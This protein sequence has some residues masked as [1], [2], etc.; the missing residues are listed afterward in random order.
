LGKEKTV[1]YEPN[2]IAASYCHVLHLASHLNPCSEYFLGTMTLGDP[3][4]RL[5]STICSSSGSCAAMLKN[6]AA[7]LSGKA[8]CDGPSWACPSVKNITR[9][10]I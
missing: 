10:Y 9:A 5:Q 4:I 7:A 1:H 6:L 8:F 2:T 3:N